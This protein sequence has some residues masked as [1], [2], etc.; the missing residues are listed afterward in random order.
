MVAGGIRIGVLG[1]IGPE[2]TAEFY[3][4]LIK[5]LQESGLIRNNKDFPQIIINSIPAPELIYEDISEE[6]L[7]TYVIGLKELDG[8]NVDFTVMVCNTIHLYYDKLQM[9]ISTPILN[10]RDEIGKMLI[11]NNVNSV[12]VLGTPNTIKKGLFEFKGIKSLYPTK[13]DLKNLSN[14]IFN[15]NRGIEKERQ[16]KFVKSICMKYLRNKPDTPVLLG[17]TEFAVMLGN[18]NINSINTIDI[19]VESTINK[20]LSS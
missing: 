13:S 19:L 4:K 17:C 8:L 20:C 15:F 7:K 5:R 1:G 2:S 14:S 16:V 18:E 11:Q 6:D 9:E 10:L 12:L 3:A